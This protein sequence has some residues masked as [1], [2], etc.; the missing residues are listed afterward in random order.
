MKYFSLQQA[1]RILPEVE[2]VLLSLRDLQTR[3]LQT[4][5]RVDLLWQRLEAGERVLD[6]IASVQ[7]RLDA[8][9]AEMRSLVERLET[10]GVILRDV[11]RGLI[12]FP[13]IVVETEFY[14]CWR[15]GEDSIQFWHG[16]DEGFGGRKPLWTMPGGR[17]NYA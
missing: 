5:E 14:L 12:D 9:V 7:A 11:G 17:P 15:L 8:D 13:A 16:V 6:E 1:D 3:A 2:P 4:K 10:L